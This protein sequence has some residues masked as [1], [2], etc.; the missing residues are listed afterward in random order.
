MRVVSLVPSSTETL[1]ALG[2]E[3]VACTRFCEQPD[4]RHVG[5]TKNPDIDAIVQLR[6]DLVVMDREENRIEDHDALV[7]AGLEVFV[8]DVRAVDDAIAVVGALADLSRA[9]HAAVVMSAARRLHRPIAAG[10]RRTAFVPIWRRPWMSIAAGTY[11]A[12]LLGLLGVDLVTADAADPYPTVELDAIA[13][14]APELVLVPSEPYDF[15]DTHLAE[16]SAAIPGAS[17][18]EDRRPGPVL[19]GYADPGRDRPAGCCP[20]TPELA[21]AARCQSRRAPSLATTTQPSLSAPGSQIATTHPPKPPPVIRAPN[22][23]GDVDEVGDCSVHLAVDVAKSSA[24]TP[25][26]VDHQP[27][28]RWRSRRRRARRRSRSTRRFSVTTWRAR[29]RTTSARSA[30]STSSS[31]AERSGP[32]TCSATRAL[33]HPVGVGRT[34]QGS[35]GDEAHDDVDV[36]GHGDVRHLERVAVDHRRRARRSAAAMHSWSM[37]PVGTPVAACSARLCGERQL[38]RRTIEAECQADG[39]LERC[40]RRQPG[41]GRDRRR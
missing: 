13:A 41:T 34:D 33:R 31:V 36:V 26:A 17:I 2:A 9:S 4:L 12:S 1:L 8:S 35:V 10:T 27:C 29:R 14:L 32:R 37:M 3:V 5:G 38:E 6:P 39:A 15:S 18:V 22:T 11:G 19:V 23:P 20:L 25:V 7:A 16:L 24:Q 28:P 30:A 40:A 21:L